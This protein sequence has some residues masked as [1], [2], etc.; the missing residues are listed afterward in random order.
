MNTSALK[1]LLQTT[2]ITLLLS[3]A[4]TGW[5]G[6]RHDDRQFVVF[7]DSLSDPGNFFAL[8]GLVS[9]APYD[10]VP[11]APYA[12]GSMHFSNGKTWVE[13][14]AHELHTSA[15]PAYRSPRFS[16]YAIGGARARPT[17]YV[18]LST[19]VA[20]WLGNPHRDHDEDDTLYIVV[21]GGND[22]RDAI[23]TL[24]ADPTGASSFQILTAAVTGVSDNL[25]ALIAGGARDFLIATSPD[26]ALVP[27][28]RYAGPQA[29]AAA[30]F[31]S[32]QYNLALQNLLGQLQA[33]LPIQV[34]T[35]DMYTRLHEIVAA[36]AAFELRNVDAS[37]ITPGVIAQAVCEKPDEYFFWDGIHPTRKGHTLIADYAKS[38]LRAKLRHVKH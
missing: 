32:V 5:S 13:Q 2:F 1:I 29:Q 26:L 3:L 30:H 8:T 17:G 22:V 20:S 38:L 36:P 7:G 16:N 15:G 35:L 34:T 28:I 19:Q 23:E 24:A 12:I 21:I 14:L 33:A 31:L 6:S 9:H 37:C 25:Q 27:A 4:A 11:S 18:D 10:L